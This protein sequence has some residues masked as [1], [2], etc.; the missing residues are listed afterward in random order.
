MTESRTSGGGRQHHLQDEEEPSRIS[1]LIFLAKKS[2]DITQEEAGRVT[3]GG[4]A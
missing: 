1:S 4:V 3:E 2:N